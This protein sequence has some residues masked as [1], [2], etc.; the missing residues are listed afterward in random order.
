M[1]AMALAKAIGV[2]GF[3]VTDYPPKS[4]RLKVWLGMVGRMGLTVRSMWSRSMR[5]P[6]GGAG[7]VGSGDKGSSG[8]GSAGE[9]SDESDV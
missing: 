4:V 2:E 1:A 8:D 7:G 9:E 5:G 3:A 6:G